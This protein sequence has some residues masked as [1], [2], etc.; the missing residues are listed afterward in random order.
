ME[1]KS[2]PNY[3]DMRL[4]ITI[5][6]DQP[7]PCING[8]LHGTRL[9]DASHLDPCDLAKEVTEE[10]GPIGTQQDMLLM[11]DEIDNPL[12]CLQQRPILAMYAIK[13][14]NAQLLASAAR[15]TCGQGMVSSPH[16]LHPLS[17]LVFSHCCAL[18]RYC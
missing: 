9:L 17:L 12:T 18:V 15:A 13:A 6:P 10:A 16:V 14:D 8:L 7:L 3:Y 4:L 11:W 2:L 5:Y 1:L